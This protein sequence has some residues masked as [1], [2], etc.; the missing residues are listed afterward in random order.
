MKALLISRL[1][2]A[3]FP[4]IFPYVAGAIF[5]GT[6][7]NGTNEVQ[8]LVLGEHAASIG[9]G[10]PENLIKFLE[11]DSE[12]LRELVYDFSILASGAHMRLFCFYEQVD[13]DLKEVIIKGVSLGDRQIF[14]DISATRQDIIVDQASATLTSFEKLGLQTSHFF[15]NKFDGSKNSSFRYVSEE[16]VTTVQEAP[17]ILKSR[18]NALRQRLVDDQTCQVVRDHL[19]SGCRSTYHSMSIRSSELY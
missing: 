5:L 9:M 16:I 12:V 8:A 13:T 1:R 4:Y 2:Q 6:P 7:F 15:L 18:Q 19:G 17:R 14:K 3:D 10:T 11:K